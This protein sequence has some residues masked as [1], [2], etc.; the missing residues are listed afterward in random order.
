MFP[1]ENTLSLGDCCDCDTFTCL[2][3][4]VSRKSSFWAA[5][6]GCSGPFLPLQIQ[7]TF[8]I[9]KTSSTMTWKFPF[10][11]WNSLVS[12]GFPFCILPSHSP[13]LCSKSLSA[14]HAVFQFCFQFAD[15]ECIQ[16]NPHV[17]PWNPGLW[18][19]SARLPSFLNFLPVPHLFVFWCPSS[20]LS[21]IPPLLPPS[22]LPL[23]Y[24]PPQHWLMNMLLL[25]LIS[26]S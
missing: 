5:C 17:S 4:T 15:S 16:T 21:V 7:L 19:D 14:S 20:P 18:N 1:K 2:N 10:K 12:T 3:L 23:N 6:I 24:K 8:K 13:V 26:A 9:V 25:C 22:S 11:Y